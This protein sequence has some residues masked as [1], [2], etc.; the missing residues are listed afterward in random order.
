[1]WLAGN[2][3]DNEIYNASTLRELT[4][5]LSTP[6]DEYSHF[7]DVDRIFWLST[8]KDL[9]P[10]NSIVAEKI[11]ADCYDDFYATIDYWVKEEK[12]R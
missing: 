5:I 4:E 8:K 7:E 10:V 2:E 1:M 12:N 11:I 3:E 9:C 6:E